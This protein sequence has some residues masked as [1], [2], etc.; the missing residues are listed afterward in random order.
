MSAGDSAVTQWPIVV[1]VS[2]RHPLVQAGLQAALMYERDF[3]VSTLSAGNLALRARA[4]VVVADY[5]TALEL[6][7]TLA[8]QATVQ[9]AWKARVMVVSHRDRESEIR[10]ALGLGVRGYLLLDSGI[11]EMISGVRALSCGQLYLDRSVAQRLAESLERQALTQR[12]SDVLSCI[13]DGHAN[14]TIADELGIAISTVKV[15]VKSIFSKLDV[16]TRTQAATVA[17]RRG[18][19]RTPA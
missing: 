15:H 6:F 10:T 3:A 18:L 5:E 19:A 8:R 9:E 7:A 12:E 16:N 17:R 4:D 14:Q 1:A 13:V 11:E 2:H